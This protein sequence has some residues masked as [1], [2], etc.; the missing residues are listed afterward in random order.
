MYII[1]SQPDDYFY[2]LPIVFF[3]YLYITCVNRELQ[4]RRR[5]RLREEDIFPPKWRWFARAHYFVLQKSLSRSC[6]RLRVVGGWGANR[7]ID[8]YMCLPISPRERS[9]NSLTGSETFALY[10]SKKLK[11]QSVSVYGGQNFCVARGN[12]TDSQDNTFSLVRHLL[13]FLKVLFFS[14]LVMPF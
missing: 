8:T 14:S 2:S 7:S 13:G 10:K 1:S 9:E 4:I 12:F 11:Q 6:P 3:L 5:G